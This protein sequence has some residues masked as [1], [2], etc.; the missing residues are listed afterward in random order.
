MRK[1][2]IAL[3]RES[4]LLAAVDLAAASGP[5]Q[6]E[7]SHA[8]DG[9]GVRLRQTREGPV[10]GAALALLA[11]VPMGNRM[12][13][14]LLAITASA[15]LTG[16][17]W[18]TPAQAKVATTG[19]QSAARLLLAPAATGPG[20]GWSIVP[21]RNL[22]ARTGQLAG[23]SCPRSSACTAVGDFTRGSGVVVTLAEH[24]DSRGWATQA[25]P[26]PRG[27]RLS[28]LVS[29]SCS[30]PSACT[31]VGQ[32]ISNQGASVPLAERWNGTRWSIQATPNPSAG[33]GF[34]NGVA[35]AS[36]SACT[37]V[38]GSSS[39]TLA[40]HWN[41]TRWAIQVTPNPSA[42]GGTLSGVACT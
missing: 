31:A 24:W 37:A 21:T 20:S 7:R 39:G 3:L 14:A 9:R 36:A 25:T 19:G 15:A 1:L 38:G 30:S 4:R 16:P 12:L 42:G 23:V 22:L 41:G 35:C 29:V 2:A 6:V 28:A 33:G 10:T 5:T 17:A 13:R 18:A 11:A 40:E 32:A 26:S 8:H 34:L 27:A